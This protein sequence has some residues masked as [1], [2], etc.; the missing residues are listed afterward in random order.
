[1]RLKGSCAHLGS[2]LLRKTITAFIAAFE[3]QGLQQA[4][5]GSVGSSGWGFPPLSEQRGSGS[6]KPAEAD[7]GLTARAVKE[8]RWLEICA[9][10]SAA[11]AAAPLHTLCPGGAGVSFTDGATLKRCPR[12]N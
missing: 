10:L 2:R 7:G 6:R 5:E 9:V 12:P 11:R 1:M 4:E 3:W 8:Q